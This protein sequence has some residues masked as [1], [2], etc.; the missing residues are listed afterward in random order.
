MYNDNYSMGELLDELSLLLGESVGTNLEDYTALL[1]WREVRLIIIKLNK[2]K[3]LTAL[4]T[5]A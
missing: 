1:S 5:N 2:L 3:A 4:A